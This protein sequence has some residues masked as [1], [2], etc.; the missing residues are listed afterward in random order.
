MLLL[1]GK[2][3]KAIMDKSHVII[4]VWTKIFFF[5]EFYLG[6]NN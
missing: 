1:L 5:L 4:L 3:K 6:I 2:I